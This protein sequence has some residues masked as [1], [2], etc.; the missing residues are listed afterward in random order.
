MG[1]WDKLLALFCPFNY[2][3]ELGLL[4]I[5]RE[6]TKRSRGLDDDYVTPTY[7]FWRRFGSGLE[8]HSFDYLHQTASGTI[9]LISGTKASKANA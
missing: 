5:I 3:V 6:C 1:A 9:N 2:Y 8:N 7:L 4:L